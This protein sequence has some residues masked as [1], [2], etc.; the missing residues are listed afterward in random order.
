[1]FTLCNFLNLATLGGF[2]RVFRENRHLLVFG[3]VWA[4]GEIPG[5]TSKKI[6]DQKKLEILFF[7]AGSKNV[8]ASKT[9]QF[10]F[11]FGP[12]SPLLGVCTEKT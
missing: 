11:V 1:M 5:P 12:W 6:F 8:F 4:L 9:E 7:V 10:F 3:G 2:T